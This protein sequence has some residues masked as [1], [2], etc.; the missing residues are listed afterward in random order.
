MEVRVER[1]EL[2]DKIKELIE[3]G[4]TRPVTIVAVDYIDE[5]EFELIYIIHNVS[6][7]EDALIRLRIPRDEPKVPS[8][9][10]ILPGFRRREMETRDLMGIEFEGLEKPPEELGLKRFLLHH[11]RDDI[12]PLR[13]D[14]TPP[15]RRK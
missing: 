4:F 5:N 1:N 6:T 2:R 7:N 14:Y 8:V 9:H 15:A 13:K 3:Q 11:D 12:P 10:D